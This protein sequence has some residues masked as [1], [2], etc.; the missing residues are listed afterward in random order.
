[1]IKENKSGKV[2]GIIIAV[3][4][5]LLLALLGSIGLRLYELLNVEELKPFGGETILNL[6]FDEPTKTDTVK[7]DLHKVDYGEIN[8]KVGSFDDTNGEFVYNIKAG[9]SSVDPYVHFDNEPTKLTDYSVMTMD[10][11]VSFSGLG[12]S[13]IYF[14]FDFRNDNGNGIANNAQLRLGNG[15]FKKYNQVANV[16]VDICPIE[17]DSFHVTYMMSHEKT[18][19]YIDGRLI[20]E[21]ECPYSDGATV[22]KG[23]RM[24]ILPNGGYTEDL[25][26][27]VDNLLI[28]KFAPDYDGAINKLF[29]HPDTL[30][31][32]NTDTIFGGT[33]VCEE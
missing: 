7:G 12:N 33:F 21:T 9:S 2:K 14:N 11:D 13:I 17:N 32:K 1:M 26:V 24:G 22:C 25:S 29:A 6:T 18:L 23:F 28:N 20:F 10:F 19:V 3:A 5:V 16:T 4:V 8:V 27:S 15:M 31:K 30:L